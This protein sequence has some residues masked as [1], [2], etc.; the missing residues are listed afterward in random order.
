MATVF[1]ASDRK[2][3]RDVAIKILHPHIAAVLGTERFLREI[4]I[5]AQLQHP[6]IVALIEAGETNESPARPF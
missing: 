1:Q 2:L 4:E 5:A 3:G 6:H